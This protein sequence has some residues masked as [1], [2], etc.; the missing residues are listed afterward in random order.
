MNDKNKAVRIDSWGFEGNLAGHRGGM[1]LMG[2]FLIVLGLFLA[3]GQVFQDAA[4][5]VSAFFVAVGVVM[6]AIGVRDRSD[7]ALYAGVFVTALA[8]SD[9]LSGAGVIHGQGWG[10]LFLGVAVT[11]IALI[12]SSGRRFGWAL[13]IGLLLMLWGGT[14]VA[15]SYVNFPTDKLVGPAL[16]VLLGIYIVTRN[17][18]GRRI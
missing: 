14:D 6:I 10:T 15:A 16:I 11:F 2:L 4:I 5:G 13:A 8:T 7:L 12:R 9:L 3:A 1:P 18:S 17:R